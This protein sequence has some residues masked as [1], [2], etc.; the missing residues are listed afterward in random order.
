MNKIFVACANSRLIVKHTHNFLS[1]V[2][3][4]YRLLND[5]LSRQSRNQTLVWFACIAWVYPLAM[6][7]NLHSKF[8]RKSRG[9]PS[10]MH[11]NLHSK[12][13]SNRAGPGRPR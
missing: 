9:V 6:Q 3:F 7:T 12:C 13:P 1:Y 5:A 8:P 11:T 2:T 4:Q 10:F